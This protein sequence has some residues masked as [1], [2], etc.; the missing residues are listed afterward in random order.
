MLPIGASG[1]IVA[2]S[3]G[4]VVSSADVP[5]LR[6]VA[7][8][9]SGRFFV[10][11]AYGSRAE[12]GAGLSHGGALPGVKETFFRGA[13]TAGS[14]EFAL[15]ALEEQ[16]LAAFVANFDTGIAP[17]A[18]L[19]VTANASNWAQ[20]AATELLLLKQAAARGDCDLVY[21]RVARVVMGRMT[22][23]NGLYDPASGLYRVASSTT[24]P[25]DEATLLAEAAS[26]L[27]VTFQGVP[28]GM[29]ES[30]GLDRDMDGLFDLDELVA[31]TDIESWDTDGDNYPDGYEVQW[32]TDPLTPSGP[33]ADSQ[34][35]A[36][37]A[38]VRL[39]Y[40]TT[41][42][43]KLEFETTEYTKV[44][45]GYNGGPPVARIPFNKVG[46]HHHWLTLGELQADTE[47][48]IFLDMR[49]ANGNSFVDSSTVFRTRPRATPAP[50]RIRTIDLSLGTLPTGMPALHSEVRVYQETATVGANYSVIANV[51]WKRADGSLRMIQDGTSATTNSAGTAVFDVRLPP[52]GPA[53]GTL[54]FVVQ[55]VV[56]PPGGLPWVRGLDLET[57]DTFSY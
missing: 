55:K 33:P 37:A 56:P 31:Q 14:H 51:Y 32:G 48:R 24:P 21:Y 1:E 57:V 25:I 27:P 29:G 44:A 35:P 53:P 41:S 13:G 11:G 30:Q 7:D 9:T 52:A 49:D 36:L 6:G 45:V 17:T 10:G 42:T 50:A 5:S 18:A 28:I 43:L 4:G 20:V 40:A 23:L 39:V 54:Y 26:G 8:K 2:E 15:T 46:D 47:Y 22:E 38:P 3:V 34:P 19:R 12:L 16:R